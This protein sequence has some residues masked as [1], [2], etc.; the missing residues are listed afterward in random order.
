MKSLFFAV[1]VI[2]LLSGCSFGRP[3][4]VGGSAQFSIPFGF[5]YLEE[6]YPPEDELDDDIIKLESEMILE[7]KR[8]IR[9]SN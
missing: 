3:S 1:I 7:K 4:A 9:A 5:S 6:E 8:E 2:F